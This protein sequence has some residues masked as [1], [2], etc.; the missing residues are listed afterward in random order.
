MNQ[1]LKVAVLVG[2]FFSMRAEIMPGVG[3]VTTVGP[4]KTQA[5]CEAFRD[6]TEYDLK[7]LG[8]TGSIS[9]CVERR[10]A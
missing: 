5:Q 9:K 8:F 4:F 10:E 3:A 6:D 1:L 2:W 7:N